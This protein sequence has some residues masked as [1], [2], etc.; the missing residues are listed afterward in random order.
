MWAIIRE[1]LSY[2]TFLA[3]LYFLTYSNLNFNSYYQVQHLRKFFLNTRQ[4]NNDYTK[5]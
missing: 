3:L 5:V 4:I 2:L 1:I